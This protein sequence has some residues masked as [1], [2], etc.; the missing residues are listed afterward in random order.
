[1]PIVRLIL[2]RFQTICP[3]EDNI[4]SQDVLGSRSDHLTL[5]PD[6]MIKEYKI[7]HSWRVRGQNISGVLVSIKQSPTSLKFLR[8]VKID[9]ESQLGL[10]VGGSVMNSV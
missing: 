10:D 6:I 1:M 9:H 8:V 2:F 7:S 4:T 3:L 5:M